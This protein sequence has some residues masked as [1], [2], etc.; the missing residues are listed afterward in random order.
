M[1]RDRKTRLAI[2][3]CGAVAERFHLPAARGLAGVQVCALVDRD[4]ARARSLL[5][6]FGCR[7]AK[8]C[9]DAAEVPP[10]TEAAIVAVPNAHHGPVACGLLKRGIHVLCEKPMATTVD[11]CRA[12]ISAAEQGRAALVVGHHKRFVP[13][14]RQ[15]KT[16][17]EQGVLGRVHRISGSMGM[18]WQSW[19][20]RTRFLHDA[21][22]AGGGVLIDSGVHLIDLVLWLVGAPEILDCR[23]TPEGRPVEEEAKLEF[24]TAGGVFG[25]L[26][27]SRRRMLPNLFRIEGER[28]FIEFDSYDYPS[29][30]VSSQDL[31]VC[32]DAGSVCFRWPHR[33]PSTSP[34]RYQLEHF[35]RCVRGAPVDVQNSGREAART[36]EIVT[37]AYDTLRL[38]SAVPA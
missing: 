33:P 9:G 34:Y 24:R 32:R 17:V 7:D 4:R 20:S 10:D 21:G 3:G 14:V 1:S 26:R 37:V 27:F 35:I 31:A 23:A 22:L 16:W 13:S 30:K 18:P 25:S 36:I 12:M 38:R 19:P 5:F 28:G 6:K 8:I 11:D 15:A 29:V 2:V